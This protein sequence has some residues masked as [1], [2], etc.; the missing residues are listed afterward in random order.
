MN[1]TAPKAILSAVFLAALLLITA[2]GEQEEAALP[3]ETAEATAHTVS[4]SLTL[5]AEIPTMPPAAALTPEPSPGKVPT[6][7]PESTF[8]PLPTDT[9]GP[10]GVTP[11]PA[12]PKA[13][14]YPSPS[15]EPLTEELTAFT[16]ACVQEETRLLRIP[17]SSGSA[18][19]KLAPGEAYRVLGDKDGF[20]ELLYNGQT[21][22][23][24]K[25]A[26][27]AEPADVYPAESFTAGS[28]NIHGCRSRSRLEAIAAVIKAQ[29][30]DVV[31]LQEVY[32]ANGKGEDKTDWL[33]ELALASGYPYYAFGRT[34]KF[35]EYDYGIA[36]LSKYPIVAA[37]TF[38]L[39]GWEGEEPR[40]L[41]ACSVW[42]DGGLVN[43]YNTHLSSSVMYKKSINI[44]S[45]VFTLRALGNED[46]VVA[47]DF[48]CSPPRIYE[49]MPDIRFANVTKDT[50][51]DGS[52][53]KILDNLLYTAGLVTADTEIVC[54]DGA[55]DHAFVKATFFRVP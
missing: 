36:V 48:N 32:R 10:G 40:A 25:T 19:A 42:T 7:T 43:F 22:Y 35:H 45:M 5:T 49:Y 53:P 47:G 50:F 27:T 33:K 4:Y 51:G 13:T 34:C 16:L 37:D 3:A 15:G 6:P 9:P 11:T 24:D 41:L 26:F 17:D 20:Y 55:T 1:R 28:L 14:P 38:A 52:V 39:D 54:T 18:L 30:T 29:D 31:G 12:Q 23:A 44:A 21:G 2:C 8:V 46:Y